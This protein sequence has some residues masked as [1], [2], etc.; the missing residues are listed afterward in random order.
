MC[1]QYKQGIKESRIGSFSRELVA[2]QTILRADD[3]DGKSVWPQLQSYN[4]FQAALVTVP[5]VMPLGEC[6]LDV[7]YA[8]ACEFWRRPAFLPAIRNVTMPRSVLMLSLD[9]QAP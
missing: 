8:C 1:K 6:W 3:G 4:M 2:L 7:G 9:V 5:Q